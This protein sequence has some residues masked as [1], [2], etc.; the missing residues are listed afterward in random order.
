MD[1]RL[2]I[3]ASL[4]ACAT[5]LSVLRNR[6]MQSSSTQE[7]SDLSGE[8]DAFKEGVDLDAGLCRARQGPLGAL[9]RPAQSPDSLR[10]RSEVPA[11]LALKHLHEVLHYAAEVL[12]YAAVEALAVQ[13][14]VSRRGS[15]LE[16]GT[17]SIA[18]TN[19]LKVPPPRLKMSTF[20]SPRRLLS[21]T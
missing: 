4:S 21:S 17:L 13:V 14:R 18:N 9:A 6:S 11:M 7:P 16:H 15:Q 12:H 5:G 19:T 3:L 1:L 2:A 8:V 10:A 20:L